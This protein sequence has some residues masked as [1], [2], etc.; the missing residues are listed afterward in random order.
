MVLHHIYAIRFTFRDCQREDLRAERY[1]HTTIVKY[2]QMFVVLNVYLLIDW[3]HLEHNDRCS[4]VRFCH[5]S[6][7]SRRLHLSSFMFWLLFF[8]PSR[9]ILFCPLRE[10]LAK[11][12]VHIGKIAK[13]HN[14][15]VDDLFL[16]QIPSGGWNR[17]YVLHKFFYPNDCL[18]FQSSG[19]SAYVLVGCKILFQLLGI[20][21]S[22][23][24]VEFLSIC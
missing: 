11:Q 12:L 15:T 8:Y 1:G 17:P 14:G 18:W 20:I 23:S 19:H 2:Q 24:D 4:R 22:S 6:T 16:K 5:L 21:T 7:V 3:P 10:V 9:A 13:R